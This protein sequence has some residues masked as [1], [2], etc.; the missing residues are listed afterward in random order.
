MAKRNEPPSSGDKAKVRVLFA[1]VEGNNESIQQ[2]LKTMVSAMTR[3]GR[4]IS[5][6]K[7]NGANA[8]LM[9]ESDDDVEPV[10]DQI[11]EV[12]PVEQ[13][14]DI[15]GSRKTRGT[16]KKVDRNAGL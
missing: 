8:L 7:I 16:G 9:Q 14:A 10:I 1:E 12:E 4:T 13:Q 15:Q 3:P 5:E 2:A 11:E 6:Q